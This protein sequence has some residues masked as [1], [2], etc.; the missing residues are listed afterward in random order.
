MPQPISNIVPGELFFGMFKGDPGTGKTLAAASFPDPIFLDFDERLTPIV[1]F[2]G[3][4]INIAFERFSTHIAITK[5]L[6]DLYFQHQT[7]NCPYKTLVLDSLTFLVKFL[8]LRVSEMK[9]ANVGKSVGGVKVSDL[10]DYGAEDAFLMQ[11]IDKLRKLRGYMHV[12][13]TAHVIQTEEKN[14]KTGVSTYSRS[15][16]TG[17][18]KIAKIIPGAFDECYHFDLDTSVEPPSHICY[19]QHT[20]NDWAKTA[21]KIPSKFEFGPTNFYEIWRKEV[22]KS[23]G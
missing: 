6:D 12:I 18:K 4:N 13:V 14:I 10:E 2:Y 9:G 23:R 22:E 19:T 5:F 17:G 3:P 21:L 11:I 1:T 16:L 7:R 8:L 20:G 15:L